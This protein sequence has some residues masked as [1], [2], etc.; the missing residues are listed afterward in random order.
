MVIAN[1]HY[2]SIEIVCLSVIKGRSMCRAYVV[3]QL[4]FEGKILLKQ[5]YCPLTT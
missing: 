2:Q 4:Q 1:D 5:F 3:D